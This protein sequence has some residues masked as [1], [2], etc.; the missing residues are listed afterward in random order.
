MDKAI[1][2]EPLQRGETMAEFVDRL[3]RTY[4]VQPH[5]AV[6]VARHVMT[7]DALERAR[8]LSEIK[9]VI[10]YLMEHIHD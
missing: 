7:L 2:R 5:E 4:R 8:S 1:W 10:E 3:V 6:S 9:P